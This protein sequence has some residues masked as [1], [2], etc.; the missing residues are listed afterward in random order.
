MRVFAIGIEHPLMMPMDRLRH[1]HLSEDHR[2]AVLGGA[3]HQMSGRLH[4]LRFVFDFGISF[5]SH[6]MASA[7]V[8]SFRPSGNSIGSS[9]RAGPGHNATPQNLEK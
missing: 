6:A 5:A 9:K 8:L 1:S 2:P 3:R 7:R 4:L